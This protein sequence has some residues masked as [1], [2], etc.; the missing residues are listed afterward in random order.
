MKIDDL[1]NG[2]TVTLRLGRADR[3]HVDWKPWEQSTIYI[4]RHEGKVVIIAVDNKSWAEYDPRYD[5]HDGLFTCED[6]YMEIQGL[7]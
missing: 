7:L 1:Q 4:Q 5:Y 3:H 2:Q 6:Y